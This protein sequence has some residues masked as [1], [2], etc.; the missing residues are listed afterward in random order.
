MAPKG[1]RVKR[2]LR[3]SA[4]VAFGIALLMLSNAVAALGLGQLEMK[5]K[6]GEPFLAEI[7]I[8]SSDPSELEQLQARV[9]TADTFARI[10][11]QGPDE[12]VSSLRFVSALDAQGRP[13]IRVTSEQPINEPLLTF[14]VEVDWGQGRLVREYSALVAAPR[15]VDAPLQPSIQAP[16]VAPS[17]AIVREPAAPPPDQTPA[18]IAATPPPPSAT[19]VP[20]PVP[21]PRAEPAPVAAIPAPVPAQADEQAPPSAPSVA[22][23]YG[24]AKAGDSLSE[25]ARDLNL[26]VSLERAMVA[27]LRANPDAFIN[28]DI[29]QLK[30]GAVL[31]VPQPSELSDV[32]AQQANELVRMQMQRFQQARRPVVAPESAPATARATGTDRAATGTAATVTPAAPAQAPA[33]ASTPRRTGAR[34]EIVPPGANQA[35]QAGTQSGLAAGGEGAMLRQEMDQARETLAARDV[36]LTEMRARVAE[37]EKLQQQQQQLIA[38]KDS[39]LATAQ[40]RMAEARQVPAAPATQGNAMP[41]IVGGVVLLALLAVVAIVARRQARARQFRAPRTEGQARAPSI[42]DAFGDSAVPPQPA[43]AVLPA[44][45]PGIAPAETTTPAPSQPGAAATSPGLV[46]AT[47]GVAAGGSRPGR[48]PR[49][50]AVVEAKP[51][52]MSAPLP[53]VQT[54]YVRGPGPTLAPV[55]A[56]PAASPAPAAV[57]TA[58]PAAAPAPTWHAT[59]RAGVA[60]SNSRV[61]PDASSGVVSASAATSESSHE[62]LEL[63]RAYLDLGD[64]ASARQL[65]V[66][67]VVN[68]D[69]ASRQQAS[70][71]LRELD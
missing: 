49:K 3:R 24:P 14:L 7:P 18:P 66:E 70:K 54:S 47:T 55:A 63:A 50:P 26:G 16:V 53:P 22:S 41:W 67:L 58:P 60:S 42:A 6:I 64:H 69:L 12:I 10:G 68:G 25:I 71:L 44:G 46:A 19:P 30:R 1:V 8:V 38:L 33:S 23:E 48:G 29:N 59:T 11:L 62:R 45:E 56:E 61:D 28:G 13:V 52:T 43:N 39:Q 51:K 31:R 36:E 65:L 2:S 37:L 32:D 35:R 9:P 17:N 40:Q 27:L 15:T 20:A 57:F 4:H 34:L 21:T 5:S